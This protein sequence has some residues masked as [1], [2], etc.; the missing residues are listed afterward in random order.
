MQDLEMAKKRDHKIQITNEAIEKVPRIRY[1][2]IPEDEYD[3]LQDIAKSVLSIS[4]E[5]NDSNEVAITYKLG[6]YQE[7]QD[8][9]EYLG[10]SLGNEH[11]VDP[12][13][14]ATAYH[15]VKSSISCVVVVFHN[16]PSLSDFSLSDV[17]FLL[18]YGSVKMMVVVT[19]LGSITYLVKT[20]KYDYEKAV[21][22]LNRAISMN[23]EAKNLKDLQKAA[24]YFLKNCGKVGIFYNDR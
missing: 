18:S 22:L 20:G 7:V 3:T 23:N 16:H 5:E 6:A 14:N 21:T 19:N 1:H 11:E 15:L 10:V 2:E 17:Q 8:G 9:E 12:I 4:K 24:D 13:S